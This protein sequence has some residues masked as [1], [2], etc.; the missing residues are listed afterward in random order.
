MGHLFFQQITA[1]PVDPIFG[2]QAAFMADPRPHKMN[3]SVGV[4]LN[5]QLVIPILES[6]K[7]AE[8]FLVREEK[9]KTYLP[10][11]GEQGY[12]E[13]MGRLV[14][15]EFLWMGESKR[16]CGVQGIGGT[17]CLRIGGEFLHQAVGDKI[18]ISDP[19]WPNHKG[20][21]ERCQMKVGYYHYFD[22]A[23]RGLNFEKTYQA[24]KNLS[25]GTVV[26]L[27]ACCHNP[28]G[29][30]FSMEEWK[31]VLGLFQKNGL[32]PFFDFA[33]QGWG[34]GLEEDAAAIRL[35]AK[36]GIEMLVSA[37][38]SKNFGLYSERIGALFI[39]T[40]S[41]ERSN[42]V[43]SKLKTI[44]RGNYSNPPRHGAAI[45]RHVLSTPELKLK[46]EQELETMRQRI[47]R[48]R[49]KLS[50]NLPDSSLIAGGQGMFCMTGLT[51]EGVER[52]KKE[53][54]I[55]LTSD[56]RMNLAGLAESNL[57]RVVEA[58]C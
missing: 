37:S 36:S 8:E 56:G 42:V 21:F 22:K 53:F 5:D 35:F 24:L 38:Q 46:W 29:F 4:Y 40:E 57:L 32:L 54:A 48:V 9:S 10:I 11:S 26:V 3:L 2:L 33:Y 44:I 20:V 39:V 50:E 28:T 47:I 1:D 55:Y 31:E 19:T 51:P 18:V 16:I 25:C 34:K 13:C 45:I 52:V 15:G 17:G 6:V 30:D 41:K 43:L 12:I 23:K 7:A 58:L 14:F 49:K 27:H